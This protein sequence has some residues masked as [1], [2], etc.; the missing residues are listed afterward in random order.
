MALAMLGAGYAF[1]AGLS[2]GKD[3][4]A[5]PIGG[6]L[7]AFIGVLVMAAGVV[8]PIAAICGL[9]L[10]IWKMVSAKPRKDYRH[11]TTISPLLRDDV[12]LTRGHSTRDRLDA[13]DWFQLEK[14]VGTLFEA[15]GY[16]TEIRGGASADGGIDLIVENSDSRIAVQCKHWG[17]WKCGVGVVRELMGSM[18]HDGISQ[19]YLVATQ[20]SPD[21]RELAAKHSIGIMDREAL[22]EWVEKAL[23][24]D[25]PEVRRA[26]EQ[27]EKLCPK[28]GSTM[29]KRTSSRG[30]NPGSR[31]WGCSRYPECKQ[32]M[33]L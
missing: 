23:A 6:L 16:R 22:I 21:A 13:L 17:K 26:L 29:V 28:C 15:S 31:F 2:G 1:F 33:N 30:K 8:V 5:N 24:T 4:M 3:S 12:S 32:T 7:Q 25:N 9:A 20:I 14:L 18:L 11:A 19:G 27:P 10:P